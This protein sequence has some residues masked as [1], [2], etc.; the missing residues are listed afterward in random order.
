MKRLSRHQIESLLIYGILLVVYVIALFPIFWTFMTSIK[1]PTEA[2]LI[3][4]V[5]IFNPSFENYIDVFLG[6]PFFKYML[7]SFVMS[8][9]ATGLAAIVGSLAGYSFAR[10]RFRG[11]SPLL[12]GLLTT[13]MVPAIA[14]AIPMFIQFWTWGMLDTY[15][16][17]I[18]VY[19]ARCIGYATWMMY[20]FFQTVP[21]EMEESAMID[22]CSRLG[23]LVRIVL[24]LSA[25][26]LVSFIIMN[27]VYLWNEF[28]IAVILTGRNTKTLPV[29]VT[30]F[31]AER[32]IE[33]G[34]AC[35]AA[36]VIMLPM[37]I[38]GLSL[39]KYIV[40]GMVMGAVKG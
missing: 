8:S 12:F 2:F 3:P 34:P 17:V 30:G 14:I 15:P 18:L 28:L 5:W 4:P 38:I 19:T 1:N 40:K 36:T 25:P 32:G 21:R 33:W 22:G 31:V 26:G 35:A 13:R 23:A 20:A 10:F 6:R 9:S 29:A 37:M 7:N 16:A 27:Y 39:Q 24:P 11:K